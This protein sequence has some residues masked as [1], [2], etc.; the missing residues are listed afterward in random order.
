[1]DSQVISCDHVVIG[2]G[3]AGLWTAIHLAER[4]SVAVLTKSTLRESSTEYAQGGIAV[5]LCP[6]DTPEL[7]EQD[8]LEAGAG[9]CDEPAVRVL[10]QEGPQAV[11]ELIDR[12]AQFD[13]ENGTLLYGREA[14]HRTTRIVHAY[15]DATG[16]EVER[17]AIE[18]AGELPTITTYE[19]SAAAELIIADGECAG[20]E[21]VRIPGGQ[22]MRFI[23]NSVL[24]ATGGAGSLFLYSTN[25]P[26][27]TA[28]GMALAL[29]AGCALQDMEF[30]QFHP[31][32]LA[33]EGYPKFLISE[34][35]RGEGAV[36]VN[37][38]G[39]AFM[40]EYHQLADLA[41]RDVVARAIVSEM[42][43]Q[44]GQHVRLDFSPIPAARI[45]ERFP[46][47]LDE[48]RKR[49]FDPLHSAK[50]VCVWGVRELRR[51]RGQPAGQQLT[52]GR[53]GVRQTHRGDNGPTGP[54]TR[55]PAAEG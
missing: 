29:R 47:I 43:K 28:D 33:S 12:G 42:R 44:G 20:V 17:T 1:M 15:G 24:I 19:E 7:H 38:E 22:R 41:P 2:S 46:G 35:V 26:V 53:A 54:S 16:A 10:T 27:A 45:K 37:S 51:A 13:R 14:A 34:A 4:G 3:I 6:M 23:A 55:R 8:T 32:A 48:L 11:Q 30:V 5:A 21:V 31:T 25:P 52:A 39:R 18:A 49:G 40:G 36:L 9:L 50:A